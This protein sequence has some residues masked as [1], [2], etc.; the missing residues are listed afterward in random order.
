MN[1]NCI[2][3]KIANSKTALKPIILQA[4]LDLFKEGKQVMT[5]KMVRQ[6]CILLDSKFPK[7][8]HQAAIA[9][10]MRNAIKCG[11]R[12][13]GEDRDFND[14]TISFDG[15]TTILEIK[16]TR[17]IISKDIENRNI[18][19]EKKSSDNKIEDLKEKLKSNKILDKIKD[20]SKN[21]LLIISCSDTKQSGGKIINVNYYFKKN[22]YLNLIKNREVRFKEYENY[23]KNN[24]NYFILKGGKPILRNGKA[25]LP[26]YFSKCRTSNQFL[27]AIDRYDGRFYTEELRKLYREKNK[28]N[29]HILI[30]SSLY[31][32]IKFDDSIIDY[33]LKIETKPFW[34]KI[35]NT[36]IKDTVIEYIKENKIDNEM[37]F[38]SLSNKGNYPYKD[39]LDPIPKW[40]DIWINHDQG[41]TSVRFLRDHFLNEL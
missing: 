25:V 35:N 18:L 4:I 20:K 41:D 36:T 40:N 9:T 31:G 17:R 10:S 8:S 12:I 22:D 15:S 37:V 34:T 6:R 19:E 1:I 28:I 29:L 11:G 32:I 21:K 16:S 24:P 2:N 26:N 5:L 33:H 30:I 38:Y 3:D 23:L 27:S 13:I 39:A 14:F 7:T